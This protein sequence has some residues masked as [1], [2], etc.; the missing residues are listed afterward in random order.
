MDVEAGRAHR[1]P[2]ARRPGPESAAEI[3]AALDCEPITP[4]LRLLK[5]QAALLAMVGYLPR[6]W[7]PH[8]A[9]NDG[10][11]RMLGDY[12][13]AKMAHLALCSDSHKRL[14][15]DRVRHFGRLDARPNLVPTDFARCARPRSE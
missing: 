13:S 1:K 4:T 5:T 11:R 9:S 3:E 8:R 6:S 12:E 14:Q 2:S 7:F 15:S 10:S